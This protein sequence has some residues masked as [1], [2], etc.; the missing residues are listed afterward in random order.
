M[1][2]V[3]GQCTRVDGEAVVAS[4]FLR[5]TSL[6]FDAVRSRLYVA[7]GGVVRVLSI[8]TVTVPAAVATLATISSMDNALLPL[9]LSVDWISN[10]VY[11]ADVAWG[12]RCPGRG[13]ER[14]GGPA[15]PHTECVSLAD[16]R[17]GAEWC[18]PSMPPGCSALRP[19]VAMICA[20]WTATCRSHAL[21]CRCVERGDAKYAGTKP[22]IA[23]SYRLCCFR[24]CAWPSIRCWAA[25]W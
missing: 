14:V 11:V 19:V 1:A 15:A 8:G 2:G 3:A 5:P 10:N 25:W 13:M 24:S 7:D 20:C 17:L 9:G 6:A 21:H 16:C 12:R 18:V 23:V 4:R 22:P